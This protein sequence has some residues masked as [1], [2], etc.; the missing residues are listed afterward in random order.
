MKQV[1][2]FTF[3]VLV[4]FGAATYAEATTDTT[5]PSMQSATKNA[6]AASTSTD[7]GGSAMTDAE[8]LAIAQEMLDAWSSLDWERVY[9][10]HGEDGALH[11]MMIDP[12]V[13]EENLR[14]RLQMFETGLTRM[15][16]V[17]LRMGML[18]GNVVVERLDSFDFNGTTGIVPVTGV[19][20]IVDRHVKLWREYYDRNWLLT[21]M[22]VAE[23]E[24][25]HPIA[26]NETISNIDQMSDSEKLAVARAMLDAYESLDWGAAAS[27]I[28]D[29]GVVHYVEKE[30]MRG[31]EAMRAHTDRMGSALTRVEF[32]DLH[33][34][35]IDG[36]VVIQRVDDFDYNGNHVSVPVFGSMEI[37]DGKI[38][39]W[40]EYYDHEQMLRGMGVL[41]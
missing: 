16:F 35:V 33:M 34:G 1:K 40:R 38:K 5:T 37:A 19:M 27:L 3:I 23:G 22:G 9:E 4:L 29:E 28:A 41:E 32:K 21:E 13:G 2:S 39:V 6:E 30:P 15:D 26:P 12:I 24:P 10:L 36:V 18:D 8:K 20:T 14:K 25:A 17:V 7:T 31:P 11:N